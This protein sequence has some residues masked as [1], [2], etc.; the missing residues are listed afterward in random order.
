[1]AADPVLVSTK[2]KA[3]GVLAFE[4]IRSYGNRQSPRSTCRNN[5]SWRMAFI[6][7]AYAPSVMESPMRDF[8]LLS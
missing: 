4:L 5:S 7:A 2:W 8:W 6:I 1:M 3:M